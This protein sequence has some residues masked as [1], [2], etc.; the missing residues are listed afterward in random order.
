M[1]S[2]PFALSLALLLLLS[3]TACNAPPILA[4]LQTPEL[5]ATLQQHTPIGS[6]QAQVNAGL[7]ALQIPA[8][9]R[10]TY[11]PTPER[12]ETVLLARSFMDRGF[13]LSGADSDIQ[14]MD[15]SYVFSPQDRL[16]RVLVFYDRVRYN[17][18]WPTGTNDRPLKG[19]LKQYPFPIPPP[20]DPLQGATQILPPG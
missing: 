1:R 14:W 6:T 9:L 13:W 4:R 18:G 17:E 5:Q 16:E 10:E 12:P 7:D 20:V 15:I 11:L 19:P 3:L 2:S 8:G